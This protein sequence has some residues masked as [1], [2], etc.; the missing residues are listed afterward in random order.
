MNVPLL[1]CF[2][3]SFHILCIN[4]GYV[5]IC[6]FFLCSPLNFLKNKFIL[7][8]QSVLFLKKQIF[9]RVLIFIYLFLFKCRI[10]NDITIRVL[11]VRQYFLKNLLFE[12]MYRIF[13]SCYYQHLFLVIVRLYKRCTTRKN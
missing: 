11:V 9:E 13:Q 10:L 3:L 8:Y 1:R 12:I 4:E 5:R 6:S 7:L 2:F